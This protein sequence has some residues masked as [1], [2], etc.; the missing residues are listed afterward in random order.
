MYTNCIFCQIVSG[1]LPSEKVFENDQFLVI[2]NKFPKAPVHLLVIP[3]EHMPSIGYTDERD[4]GLLGEIM[5]LGAK[6]AKDKDLKDFKL[7]F[8]NGKYTQIPH[9]HLHLVSGPALESL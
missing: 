9:L 1:E 6:T 5:A 7:V 3:K 2:E 8:N 4:A